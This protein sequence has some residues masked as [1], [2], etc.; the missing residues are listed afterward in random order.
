MRSFFIAIAVVFLVSSIGF[1]ADE[2]SLRAG[3]VYGNMVNSNEWDTYT[4]H[5]ASLGLYLTASGFFEKLPVAIVGSYSTFNAER[6]SV[7]PPLES[8]VGIYDIPTKNSLFKVLVGYRLP[9]YSIAIGGGYV[10]HSNVWDWR[11]DSESTVQISG[12][13][14]AVFGNIPIM[15]HAQ[16]G[17]QLY[18]CPAN[19]VV[20][21]TE[22]SVDQ[23][24]GSGFGY[25]L[26]GAYRLRPQISLEAGY[27]GYTS[28]IVWSPGLIAHVNMSTLH[29]GAKYHF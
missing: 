4:D 7:N 26:S 18:Y 19:S 15:N 14:V 10:S 12:I 6:V 29:V 25:E 21:S 22:S 24:N 3:L 16:L 20:S 5:T 23:Y 2:F 8:L 17:A 1:T 28:S 13:T 27:Q 11:S 9:K